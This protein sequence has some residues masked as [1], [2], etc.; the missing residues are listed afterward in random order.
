MFR[1][2]IILRHGATVITVPLEQAHRRWK[3]CDGWPAGP[4]LGQ[5]LRCDSTRCLCRHH[6]CRWT[7]WSKVGDG[8]SPLWA[9]AAGAWFQMK[10]SVSSGNSGQAVQFGLGYFPASPQTASCPRRI[11]GDGRRIRN[12]PARLLSFVEEERRVDVFRFDLF[13][14]ANLM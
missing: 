13:D 11:R 7:N 1:F 2:G 3:M 10:L 8:N 9:C 6:R 4:A 5:C 12:P 14:K